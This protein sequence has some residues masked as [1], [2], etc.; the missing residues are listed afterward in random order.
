MVDTSWAVLGKAIAAGSNVKRKLTLKGSCKKKVYLSS[1]SDNIERLTGG[2]SISI[3]IL[4]RGK[5][6]EIL[7]REIMNQICIADSD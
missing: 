3:T 6:S 4:S 7:L 1:M 2:T 5:N